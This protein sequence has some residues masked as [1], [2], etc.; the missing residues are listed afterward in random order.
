MSSFLFFGNSKA[1]DSKVTMDK[2][3][4]EQDSIEHISNDSD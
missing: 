1:L 4:F 2:F 3:E